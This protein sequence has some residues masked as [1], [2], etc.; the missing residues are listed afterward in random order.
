MTS[1]NK[2]NIKHLSIFFPIRVP[3]GRCQL[4][5]VCSFYVHIFYYG[6][7]LFVFCTLNFLRK[8]KEPGVLRCITCE[9][10]SYTKNISIRIG[11]TPLGAEGLRW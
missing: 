6:F 8:V 4:M 10:Q 2:K 5:V 7:F 3:E 1:S 11:A 9:K